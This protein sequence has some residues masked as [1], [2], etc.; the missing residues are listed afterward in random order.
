M[1]WSS[2]ISA[3]SHRIPK[4]TIG[5][6]TT[7]SSILPRNCIRFLHLKSTRHRCLTWGIKS[8]SIAIVEYTGRSRLTLWMDPIQTTIITFRSASILLDNI[9]TNK[10]WRTQIPNLK[11]TRDPIKLA[12]RTVNTRLQIRPLLHLIPR[13][14]HL[15]RQIL[16]SKSLL[17][18]REIHERSSWRDWSRNVAV[19][20][21]QRSA[22]KVVLIET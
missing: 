20:L 13:L 2:S 21:L 5:N 4:A 11:L 15:L 17:R 18:E 16:F 14:D 12:R 7:R 19:S 8:L 10:F 9:Q 3:I 22:S 6:Q 1:K